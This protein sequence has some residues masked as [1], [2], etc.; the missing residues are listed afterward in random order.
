M[1]LG[2]DPQWGGGVLPKGGCDSSTRIIGELGVVR[3]SGLRVIDPR[4]K[5]GGKEQG[6]GQPLLA[7][8]DLIGGV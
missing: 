2:V 3:T 5:L 4:G 8:L 6:H 7:V 1:V